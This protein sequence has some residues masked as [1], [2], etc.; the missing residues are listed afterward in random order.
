MFWPF[1]LLTT[2]RSSMRLTIETI[3]GAIVA[4]ARLPEFYR[5]LAVP[6]SVD[7]RFDMVVLH[8]WLVLRTWRAPD[9]AER[10]QALIDRFCSDMDHNLRE[11]GVGDLTVPKRMLKFG[12]A[13]YGRA[14][15]YDDALEAGGEALAKALDRNIYNGRNAAA[16]TRLA[17]YVREAA[18]DD[19]AACDIV[20]F[21]RPLP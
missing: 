9:H 15:A 6:D 3:Y 12:E 13:L 19:I 21:P 17:R 4:Q 1:S 20:H 2:S 11:L 16:A 10:S 14:R 18:A 5:D 7:G 8:M